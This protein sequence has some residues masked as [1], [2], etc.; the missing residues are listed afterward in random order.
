MTG[1]SIGGWSNGGSEPLVVSGSSVFRMSGGEVSGAIVGENGV[2]QMSGGHVYAWSLDWATGLSVWDNA[3]LEVTGGQILAKGWRDWE[4][5][6]GDGGDV[7][8]AMWAGQRNNLNSGRNFNFPCSSRSSRWKV[9]SL[10]HFKTAPRSSGDSGKVKR[11]RSCW[12]R[13][14]VRGCCWRWAYYR[15]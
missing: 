13:S 11:P 10:V 8:L 7:E 15:G 14:R 1:G 5:T 9:R 3:Q 12:Y 6:W 2:F 4:G